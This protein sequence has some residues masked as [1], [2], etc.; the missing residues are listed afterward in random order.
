MQKILSDCFKWQKVK[1]MLSV[2][3]LWVFWESSV[4]FF[5][6]MQFFKAYKNGVITNY[7]D[8]NWSN[9]WEG[10]ILFF[11]HFNILFQYFWI[12]NLGEKKAVCMK[13]NNKNTKWGNDVLFHCSS[14]VSSVYTLMPWGLKEWRSRLPLI[15]SSTGVGFGCSRSRM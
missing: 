4:F 6:Q 10:C 9:L 5:K 13:M 8:L 15:C 14:P 12:I 3:N 11:H 7:L 2:W 1:L